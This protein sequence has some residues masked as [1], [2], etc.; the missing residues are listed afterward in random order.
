MTSAAASPATDPVTLNDA[1][2][3]VNK[4]KLLVDPRFST[5]FNITGP[6][7][8][9]SQCLIKVVRNLAIFKLLDLNQKVDAASSPVIDGQIKGLQLKP[10]SVETR[11]SRSA[12][13]DL[14]LVAG[15][16]VD[17]L[18]TYGMQQYGTRAQVEY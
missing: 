13:P 2:L 16:E 15:D 5:S 6:P 8:N 9:R 11:P 4:T 7:F 17:G 18:E 1:I 10:Q 3:I 14:G 12:L